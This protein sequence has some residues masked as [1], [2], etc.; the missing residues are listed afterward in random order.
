MAQVE[1]IPLVTGT[2]L[3]VLDAGNE[4]VIV[5]VTDKEGRVGVGGSDARVT[6]A[7]R[8]LPTSSRG[9]GTGALSSSTARDAWRARERQIGS[10]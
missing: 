2:H 8:R 9:S 7:A 6:L 10:R 1:A 4:T 5:R 3:T